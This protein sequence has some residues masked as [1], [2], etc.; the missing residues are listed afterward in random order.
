ML[1]ATELEKKEREERS[2]AFFGD[3]KKKG[4]SASSL[5]SDIEREADKYLRE[6]G[7]SERTGLRGSIGVDA[8]SSTIGK[9]QKGDTSSRAR[10]GLKIQEAPKDI[11]QDAVAG[12]VNMQEVLVNVKFDVNGKVSVASDA[13]SEGTALAVIDDLSF[14]DRFGGKGGNGFGRTQV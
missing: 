8:W 10:Q 6:A 4:G 1:E 11:I 5:I 14:A 9:P 7:I 3:K 2:K 12:G 13:L